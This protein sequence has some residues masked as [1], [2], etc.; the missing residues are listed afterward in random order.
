MVLSYGLPPE[1]TVEHLY[2]SN[3]I[4]VLIV[5]LPPTYLRL[6]LDQDQSL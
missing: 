4:L 5:G 6:P 1:E 2:S 3:V